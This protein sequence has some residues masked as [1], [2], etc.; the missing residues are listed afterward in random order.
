MHSMA[1]HG[2]GMTVVE[3]QGRINARAKS[4]S[5]TFTLACGVFACDV[6]KY[7]VKDGGYNQRSCLLEWYV[8]LKNVKGAEITAQNIADMEI[9]TPIQ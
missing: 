8:C 9:C 5:I 7:H 1:W 6:I 3:I 2:M 4:S